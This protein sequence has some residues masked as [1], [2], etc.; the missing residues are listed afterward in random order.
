MGVRPARP[1]TDRR[2]QARHRQRP[3]RRPPHAEQ[4]RESAMRTEE[5]TLGEWVPHRS[6]S[7]APGDP[8]PQRSAE[9]PR[10]SPPTLTIPLPLRMRRSQMTIQQ[11][12]EPPFGE[13]TRP[14]RGGN[15]P[16]Q[17]TSNCG[18]HFGKG[19]RIIRAQFSEAVHAASQARLGVRRYCCT[20]QL[21]RQNPSARSR[22]RVRFHL[23]SYHLPCSSS[24]PSE[25]RRK[26]CRPRV[27]VRANGQVRW[28]A[29]GA[30]AGSLRPYSFE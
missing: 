13:L 5:L 30:R 4:I 15:C 24:H 16:T 10:V 17:F 2:D 25:C 12:C 9:A 21:R 27:T 20:T 6:Q 26:S 8:L 3:L 1:R 29:Q 23:L 18:K 7:L 11:T 19:D 14:Q 22:L 28:W